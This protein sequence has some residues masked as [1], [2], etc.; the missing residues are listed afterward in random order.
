ML[1]VVI[2]PTMSC[3]SS[4]V[5]ISEVIANVPVV[6]GKVAVTFPEYAL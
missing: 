5:G 6:T 1:E 2:A 3:I 4:V